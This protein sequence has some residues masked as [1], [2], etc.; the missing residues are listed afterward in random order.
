MQRLPKFTQADTV[1]LTDAQALN[2]QTGLHAHSP[3]VHLTF[4]DLLS[5]E[6]WLP[7]NQPKRFK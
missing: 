2:Q 7:S 1:Y 6:R 3:T 4:P 5:L